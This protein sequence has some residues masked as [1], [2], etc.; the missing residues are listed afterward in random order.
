VPLAVERGYHLMLPAP[1]L[2]LEVPVSNAAHS[3]VAT[4]MAAGLRLAG[5]VE[6]AGPEAAPDWRRAE[7][8]GVHARRMLPGLAVA[9]AS[10]WMGLR[11]SFPDS[12]PAI[13]RFPGVA[14]AFAAFGHGH[15]GLSLSPMTGRIVADMVAGRVPGLDVSAFRLGRF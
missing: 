4:P 9:G 5:T 2:A 14:N 12:L 10:R 13:D 7:V 8:L 15:Y 6:I 1:G 3:F 11:P